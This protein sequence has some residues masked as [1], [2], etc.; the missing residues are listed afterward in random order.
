MKYWQ[1]NKVKKYISGPF[2]SLHSDPILLQHLVAQVYS[3]YKSIVILNDCLDSYET[4]TFQ[5]FIASVKFTSRSLPQLVDATITGFGSFYFTSV[6]LSPFVNWHMSPRFISLPKG[7]FT[8]LVTLFDIIM[9]VAKYFIS[10]NA[11]NYG[12]VVKNR[13]ID[14]FWNSF[15]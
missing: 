2:L 10:S 7:N 6:T 1:V 12:I 4:T 8:V 3:S 5:V 11:C 13:S 14:A 9:L 15:Y